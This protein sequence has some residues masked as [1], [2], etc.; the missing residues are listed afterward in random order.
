MD[1]RR[2]EQKS[3]EEIQERTIAR[4][5]GLNVELFPLLDMLDREKIVQQR[6][7]D[8]SYV[9]EGHGSMPESVLVLQPDGLKS[10]RVGVLPNH[11]GAAFFPNVNNFSEAE[12]KRYKQFEQKIEA[13]LD[14]IEGK[15]MFK[16]FYALTD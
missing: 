2:Q 5:T 8:I 6:G 3:P 7:C 13:K 10:Y 14:E 12:A 16:D 1:E 11:A 9:W 4:L 15:K